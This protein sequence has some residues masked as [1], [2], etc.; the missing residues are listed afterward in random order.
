M[1]ANEAEWPQLYSPPGPDPRL[2]VGQQLAQQQGWALTL[3]VRI[4][5]RSKEGRGAVRSLAG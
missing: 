4:W 1:E 2:L 3:T 5:N